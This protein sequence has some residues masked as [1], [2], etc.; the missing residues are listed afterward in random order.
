MAV[1]IITGVPGSGK[2]NYAVQHL[3]NSYF[4]WDEGTDG[5]KLTEENLLII[6]NIDGF[7]YSISLQDEFDKCG[8]MENFFKYE[9]QAMI[10][11][12]KKVVYL[13]DE[14]QHLFPFTCRNVEMFLY[15]QKHRHLG[16]D[17]YLIT[18]DADLLAKGL[19]ALAEYHIEAQRRSYSLA[20]EFRYR[21]VDPIT[22]D[23][24][25]TKVLKRDRRVFAFY[26]SME[27]TE[28]E[29]LKSVPIRQI[30][31][32]VA[33]FA[34]LAVAMGYLLTG[35][36]I[37]GVERKLEKAGV[38]KD[39]LVRNKGSDS[40]KSETVSPGSPGN[41]SASILPAS[42]PS[43]YG[44]LV[45]KFS[46]GDTPVFLVEVGSRIFRLSSDELT[47]LC[48]CH[49]ENLTVGLMFL[50][51]MAGALATPV[52]SVEKMPNGPG[53]GVSGGGGVHVQASK[54]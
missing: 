49:S 41:N 10:F 50:A 21:F 39:K 51:N 28:T 36:R 18:Q 44:H 25:K 43:V 30:G 29:K 47:R 4:Q 22:K 35:G 27:T 13:I 1:R 26:R 11:P 52:Y 48:G 6:S 9:Y 20:G 38:S 14:A 32:C 54:R 45:G 17:V 40:G 15:F 5:W 8:G 12:E 33:L 53:P 37:F 42:L 7:P 34:F 3:L 24:W 19:R 23:V 2:T 46:A 16:H 31:I